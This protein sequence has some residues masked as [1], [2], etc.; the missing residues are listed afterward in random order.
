MAGRKRGCPV[1]SSRPVAV[2]AA[3][4]HFCKR[5]VLK[6]ASALVDRTRPPTVAK[7]TTGEDWTAKAVVTEF[8]PRRKC[9]PVSLRVERKRCLKQKTVSLDNAAETIHPRSQNPIQL[10]RIAEGRLA[11]SL[12]LKLSLIELAV[13]R[14]YI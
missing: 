13:L 12:C 14:I 1:K 4:R 2:F 10:M 11:A 6:A 8:V 3:D 5:R 9:P 7:N